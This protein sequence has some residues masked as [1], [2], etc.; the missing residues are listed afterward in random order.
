[1]SIA[2]FKSSWS[3]TCLLLALNVNVGTVRYYQ[4]L[5][6]QMS[7]LLHLSYIITGCLKDSSKDYKLQ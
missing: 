1:M 2:L 3:Q 5:F 4:R 7:F 6:I